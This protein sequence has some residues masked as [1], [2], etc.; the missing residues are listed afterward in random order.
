MQIVDTSVWIAFFNNAKS[1]AAAHIEAELLSN[2]PLCINAIIEMEILQGIR[3][4]RSYRLTRDYLQPFQYFPDLSQRYFQQATEIYRT[5][6]RRGQTI[7]RS[8]DCLIAANALID[9]L[10]VVHQDRD[11]DAIKKT[12]P[13]LAVIRI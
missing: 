13:Q 10:I 9:N 11:F 2:Q 3:E 8:L 4:E 12:F 5:C 6:R 7:R 1:P